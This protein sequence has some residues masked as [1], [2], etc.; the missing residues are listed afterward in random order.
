MSLSETD[1]SSDQ[2]ASPSISAPDTLAAEN[3][4]AHATEGIAY[5][6]EDT[7]ETARAIVKDDQVLVYDD[8]NL[9]I[10]VGRLPDGTY[11]MAVSKP[12]YDVDEA[13]TP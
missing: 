8:S 6:T 13:I 11:G 9:R 5:R 4:K 12:G 3:V 2:R 10:V 1:R 7:I